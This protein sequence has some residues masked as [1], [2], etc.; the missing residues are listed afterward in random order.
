MLKQNVNVTM[1][2]HEAVGPEWNAAFVEPFFYLIGWGL[3]DARSSNDHLKVTVYSA[4]PSQY[5]FSH[6]ADQLYRKAAGFALRGDTVCRKTSRS[7]LA[8]Q[9]RRTSTV[10]DNFDFFCFLVN[11]LQIAVVNPLLT[12]FSQIG[13]AS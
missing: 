4:E 10:T 7:Q 6:F 3:K 5:S 2:G 11:V 8:G 1:R 9:G 12:Q 13:R